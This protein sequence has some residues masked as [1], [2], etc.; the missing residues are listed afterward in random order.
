MV[1]TA[2]ESI[3]ITL[4]NFQIDAAI[5][6]V[7]IKLVGYAEAVRFLHGWSPRMRSLTPPTSSSA[8][9]A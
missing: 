5:R 1:I 8:T 9:P 7:T 6:S 4:A 3:P 2:M